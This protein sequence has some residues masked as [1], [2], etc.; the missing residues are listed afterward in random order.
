MNKLYAKKNVVAK[1]AHDTNM[2]DARRGAA[3]RV[4][5]IMT[6]KMERAILTYD[7]LCRSVRCRRTERPPSNSPRICIYVAKVTKRGKER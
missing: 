4:G 2:H 6:V 1:Y 5:L 7:Y 3:R